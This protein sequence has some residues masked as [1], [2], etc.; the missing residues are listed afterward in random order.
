MSGP[1]APANDPPLCEAVMRDLDGDGRDEILLLTTMGPENHKSHSA[2]LFQLQADN[3]W[4]TVGRIPAPVCD[5]D[6]A[7]LRAGKLA[8]VP[9]AH[10]DIQIGDRHAALQW[11]Q[12]NPPE[13]CPQAA[14]H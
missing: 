9:A 5:S 8:F 4:R 7:L 3:A 10:P 6:M 1:F 12:P 2:V 11:I 14:P 13:Q